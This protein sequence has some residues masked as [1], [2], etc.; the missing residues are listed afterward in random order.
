MIVRRNNDQRNLFDR[1]DVQTLM[2]RTSLHPA[3]TNRGQTDKSAFTLEFFREQDPN[4]H[5]NHRA[6]VADHGQLSFSGPASVDIAVASSH[7]ALSRAKISAGDV[8]QRFAERGTSC[9][10]TN[11]WCEYVV[12]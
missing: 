8:D 1:G 7:R 9:L 10:V 6:E 4:G 12:L 11:Q 3:F 2:G 5:R